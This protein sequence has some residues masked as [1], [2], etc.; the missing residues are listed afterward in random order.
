[1]RLLYN[2]ILIPTLNNKKLRPVR[3]LNIDKLYSM[4]YIDLNQKQKK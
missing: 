1:M 4:Y 3:K 2:Y